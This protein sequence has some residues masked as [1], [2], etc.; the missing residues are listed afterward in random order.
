V[1]RRRNIPS[2]TDPLAMRGLR[3]RTWRL[4]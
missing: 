2:I 4:A 3:F 1:R